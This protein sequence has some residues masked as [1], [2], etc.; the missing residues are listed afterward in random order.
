MALILCHFNHN[1][2]VI[3]E[4]DASNYISAII[5]SQYNNEGVLH[6]VTFLSKKH[7]PAECNYKS[8]N[9]ELIAIIRAFEEW[10]PELEG[11]LH[12][13]KVLSDHKN[14]EYCMI[15]KLLNC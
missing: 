7:S 3:V 11:A 13:I 5:L 9:K 6:P 14:L 10:R 15:M 12:P 1:Q 2:E 4:T 8:N